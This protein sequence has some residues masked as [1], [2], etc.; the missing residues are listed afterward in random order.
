MAEFD[1]EAGGQD[2]L[3][4]QV[5]TFGKCDHTR[6]APEAVVAKVT[7]CACLSGACHGV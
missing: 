5:Y 3:L 4:L 2:K 7:P 1:S 6:P